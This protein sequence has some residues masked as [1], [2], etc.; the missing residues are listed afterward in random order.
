MSYSSELFVPL[1]ASPLKNT[2]ADIATLYNAVSSLARNLSQS[3]GYETIDTTKFPISNYDVAYKANRFHR[4]VAKVLTDGNGTPAAG[5]FV[6]FKDD[7]AGNLGIVKAVNSTSTDP[8]LRCSGYLLSVSDGVGIVQTHGLIL[9]GVDLVIGQRYYM[10]NT[11]GV[12]TG[13]PTNQYVGVAVGKRELLMN[14]NA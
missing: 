11:P 8:G 1:P 9:F 3:L 2:P 4:V 7:G 12:V 5:A 10:S 14:L 6:A 13:G